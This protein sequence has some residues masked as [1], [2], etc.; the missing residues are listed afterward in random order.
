MPL[1]RAAVAYEQEIGHAKAA[2]HTA[3]I[4]RLE[5]GEELPPELH[6][7]AGQRAMDRVVRLEPDAPLVR[8][9]AEPL[10][11]D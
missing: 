10:E 9:T 4:A 6:N 11:Q 3:F 1:L 7:P 5:A 8:H 2:E